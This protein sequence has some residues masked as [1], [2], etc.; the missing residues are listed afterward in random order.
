MTLFVAILIAGLCAAGATAVIRA[1]VPQ[2]WLLF[3]PFSC[4]LCMSWWTALGTTAILAVDSDDLRGVSAALT[5]LGGV[6]VA[7]LVTKA[8]NRLSIDEGH[9]A[10]LPEAEDTAS[11]KE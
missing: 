7:L 8:A 3:K 9:V 6:A 4:D 11:P 10:D 1:V 5:V 2:L